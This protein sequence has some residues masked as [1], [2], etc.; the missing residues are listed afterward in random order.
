MSIGTRIKQ[1]RE[2]LG[3][4]QHQ[5]A[6]KLGI[7]KGAVGNYETE[8]SSPK[9]DV[10]LKLFDI[11]NVSPNYLFQD[12]FT[13][14]KRIPTPQESNIIDLY[15]NLTDNSKQF[16]DSAIIYANKFDTLIQYNN[17]KES[18][19]FK[20]IQAY[21]NYPEMQQ[22]VNRILGIDF[23]QNKTSV[24]ETVEIK[25]AADEGG[26]TTATVPKKKMHPDDLLY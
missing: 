21:K 17:E 9:E 15:L 16:I 22:A 6:E 13:S 11:L 25:I 12:S 3:I 7:T 24:P 8:V 20:V 26:V 4:S 23:E 5:L 18:D 14:E 1:R 19:E 10:L 2:E